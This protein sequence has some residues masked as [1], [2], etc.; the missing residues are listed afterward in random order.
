[1]DLQ[2]GHC[3]SCLTVLCLGKNAFYV[4]LFYF[5]VNESLIFFVCSKIIPNL[6]PVH[7]LHITMALKGASFDM[8]LCQNSH[9]ERGVKF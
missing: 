5:C 7:F 2:K 4:F 3:I 8:Y 1:M 6:T 9:F